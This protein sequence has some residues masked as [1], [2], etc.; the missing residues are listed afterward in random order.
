MCGFEGK[1]EL[2]GQRRN[3]V[4]EQR[5]KGKRGRREGGV[6]KKGGNGVSVGGEAVGMHEEGKEASKQKGGGGKGRRFE[7]Y[8]RFT[9]KNTQTLQQRATLSSRTWQ[10][11]KGRREGKS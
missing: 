8:A 6:R 1:T 10:R 5:R 9:H 4:S 11:C 7:T 2:T 3:E